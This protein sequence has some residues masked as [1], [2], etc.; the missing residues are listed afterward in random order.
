MHSS[1]WVYS[2]SAKKVNWFQ[3]LSSFQY[4]EHNGLLKNYH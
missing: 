3:I 1:F 2:E 4:M